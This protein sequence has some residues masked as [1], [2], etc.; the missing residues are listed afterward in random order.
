MNFCMRFLFLFLL[1]SC[2]GPE[3]ENS[4][5]R[6]D[7][8]QDFQ[9]SISLDPIEVANRAMSNGDKRF[10]GYLSGGGLVVPFAHSGGVEQAPDSPIREGQ[11]KLIAELDDDSSVYYVEGTKCESM[12]NNIF[13]FSAKYNSH[14]LAS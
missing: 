10:I 6:N 9:I 12:L 13:D 1:S 4:G 5:G 14:I 11:Y 3:Y 7:V 2:Q 8:C